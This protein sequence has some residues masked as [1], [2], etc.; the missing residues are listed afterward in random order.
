MNYL[1]K[2]IQYLR[3]HPGAVQS[4]TGLSRVEIQHDGHCALLAGRGPCNCDPTIAG[5][6]D[7][8][9]PEEEG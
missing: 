9:W 7:M 4:E 6:E 3:E 1:P 8:D 5:A 2:L